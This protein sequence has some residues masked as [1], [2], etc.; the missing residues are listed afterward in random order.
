MKQRN[1]KWNEFKYTDTFQRL[2]QFFLFETPVEGTS[3]RGRTFKEIGWKGSSRF[4]MLERLLK[5]ASDIQEQ[6]WILKDIDKIEDLSIIYRE[7]IQYVVSS[8]DKGKVRSIIYAIRNAFA[9]GSFSRMDNGWYLFE[10]R[11]RGRLKAKLIISEQSLLE[12]IKIIQ[13]N[14]EYYVQQNKR[15]KKGSKAA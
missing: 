1:E 15:K 3:C 14:P 6:H 9:H 12:W 4:Q 8:M 10:N 5:A 7:D 2:L 11:Y 13:T